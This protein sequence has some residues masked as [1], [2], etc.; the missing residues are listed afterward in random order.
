[1]CD[2]KNLRLDKH[3][4]TSVNGRVISQHTRIF[5]AA[6]VCIC[7]YRKNKTFTNI[8]QFPVL[9]FILASE[10]IPKRGYILLLIGKI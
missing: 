8:S 2:V 10:K 5:L 9:S 7:E 4:P 1:M 6:K 3:L